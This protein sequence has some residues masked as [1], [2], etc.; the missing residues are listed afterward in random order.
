MDVDLTKPLLSK[1]RLNGRIW[2]IQYEGLKMICFHCGKQ[3]HKEDVCPLKG[4]LPSEEI[5]A[6]M[7]NAA[8]PRKSVDSRPEVAELYGSWMLVKKPARRRTA[9]QT[10]QT[11]PRTGGSSGLTIAGVNLA[12]TH[13]MEIPHHSRDANV[14]ETAEANLETPM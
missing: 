10:N 6:Q 5:N 2:L 8:H 7:S 13:R 1:F 4:D 9:W 3:G 14:M 11:A 12:N